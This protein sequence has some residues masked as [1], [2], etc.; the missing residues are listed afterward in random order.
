MLGSLLLTP[1]FAAD[2]V[3]DLENRGHKVTIRKGSMGSAPVMLHI[4]PDT[5]VIEAAGDSRARRHA[6]AY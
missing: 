5:G 3:A 1:D 6:G 4:N 2:V